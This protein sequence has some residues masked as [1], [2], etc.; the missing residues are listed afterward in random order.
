[1]VIFQHGQT[2][3]PWKQQ[4]LTVPF[5]TLPQTFLTFHKLLPGEEHLSSDCVV[6]IVSIYPG[7]SSLSLCRFK[8]R[9]HHSDQ[10]TL[11]HPLVLL[12]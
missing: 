2:L 10:K 9:R 7:L 4:I 11:H 3:N 6:V 12:G 8:L 1:M 5:F